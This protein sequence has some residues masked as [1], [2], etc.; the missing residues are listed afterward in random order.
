MLL[1]AAFL[2]S[3]FFYKDDFNFDESFNG[4]EMDWDYFG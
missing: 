4:I 2:Y 3:V 1:L